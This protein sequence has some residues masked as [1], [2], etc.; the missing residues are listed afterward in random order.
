MNE[1]PKDA[2]SREWDYAL[3]V[4]ARPPVAEACLLLQERVGVDVV[5]MLHAMYLF[6]QK[7]I[8]LDSQALAVAE[9]RVRAWRTT[10]TAPLRSLRASLKTGFDGL[11]AA[12]VEDTRLKIKA[13]ELSAEF[14]AFAALA[15]W[16]WDPGFGTAQSADGAALLTD[17]ARMYADAERAGNCREPAVRD[18][19]RTLGDLLGPRG[20]KIAQP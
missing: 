12:A 16:T 15:E 14:A 17:I 3:R 20:P 11:P 1:S 4:Y 5:V 6:S 9:A 19:I 10:V 18:A 8:A 13:A 2:L 7:G